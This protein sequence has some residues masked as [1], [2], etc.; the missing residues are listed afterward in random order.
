VEGY[1]SAFR[2]RAI[3]PIINKYGNNPQSLLA[4]LERLPAKK[5]NYADIGI[6][7]EVFEGV[8]VLVTF[9]RGDEEF[10]PEAN[11]LFDQSIS[12]IFCTEDIV[13]LA[14]F[15]AMRL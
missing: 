14:Q 6:V 7:V 10:K 3:E 4:V 8:P 5:I 2:E 9:W 1:A 15:L 13:V 11:I 12:R